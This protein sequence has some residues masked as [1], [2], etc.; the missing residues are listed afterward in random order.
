VNG[1]F[2]VPE[3]V[4]LN[5]D[6]ELVLLENNS[7]VTIVRHLVPFFTPGK[8]DLSIYL[9]EFEAARN[10]RFKFLSFNKTLHK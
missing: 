2:Q 9:D 3:L 7:K 8:L 4:T 10:V 6:A 1:T 5:L